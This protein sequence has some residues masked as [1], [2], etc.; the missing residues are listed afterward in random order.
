MRI[1]RA[2]AIYYVATSRV[3]RRVQEAW[4]EGA[5]LRHENRCRQEFR[6]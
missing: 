3:A 4:L 5:R 1:F 2:S 6:A